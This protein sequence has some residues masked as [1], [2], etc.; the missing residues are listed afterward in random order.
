[1]SFLP[2]VKI[3]ILCSALACAAGW[4]LSALGQLNRTGYAVFAGLVLSIFFLARREWMPA[5]KV[6]PWSRVR[7][8]FS[9]P[10]PQVFAVLAALVFLGGA[11]YLPSNYDGL[12]YRLSMALDSY[13]QLSHERP[14]LRF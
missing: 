14:Q 2:L 1:V 3:W 8:R 12:T 5:G 10:L 4:I 7:R 6:F 9:R 11:L 13:R